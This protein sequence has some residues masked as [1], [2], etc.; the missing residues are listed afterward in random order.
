[1]DVNKNEAQRRHVGCPFCGLVCDDLSVD[2]ASGRLRVTARGCGLSRERF[3][4]LEITASPTIDGRGAD[5]PAAIAR[6]VD[7]LA[8][9]RAPVFVVAADV[10]GT[11]AVLSLADRLGGVVDHPQSDALFRGLR[12]LQ[13][14]GALTTT[15]SEVRNRADLVLIVGP[16]PSPTMPRFFERC[17]EP[18]QTLFGD[19]PLQRKIFRLGPPV[20]TDATAPGTQVAE[21]ACTMEHLPE[22]V[23]ALAALVKGRKVAVHDTPHFDQDR[24]I[25]LA[26]RLKAARYAVVAWAPA[27]FQ[28]SGSEL[29]AQALLELA[30]DLTRT[31]RCSLVPLGGSANLFG[32]NQVCTWQTGYPIRTAFGRGVPEHDPYRFSASRMV[33]EGEADALVWI[34]AFDKNPPPE[35]EGVPTIVLAPPAT[36]LSRHVAVYMPVGVPGVDHSGEVFRADGVVALR[37]QAVRATDLPDV[38]SIIVQIGARLLTEGLVH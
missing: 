20:E 30:R 6:A 34:S 37:L 22:A 1:M 11:R 8:R 2:D 18:S 26:A 3:A 15:L 21:L 25:D 4:G 38:A 35:R 16:D 13:D 19:G 33:E 27:L 24:F 31:T 14:A 7:I 36:P 17:I 12:V 29:I 10:A 23:A 28:I 5:I 9:S 32:V